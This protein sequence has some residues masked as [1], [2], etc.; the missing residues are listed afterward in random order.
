MNVQVFVRGGDLEK[1]LRRFK[2]ACGRELVLSDAKAKDF[3]VRPGQKRRLKSV[4]A[5]IK[6]RKLAAKFGL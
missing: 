5:Q 4:R 1:A 2:K 6:R 3:Y